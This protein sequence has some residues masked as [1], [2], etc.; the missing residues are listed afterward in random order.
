M[1]CSII[2]QQRFQHQKLYDFWSRSE[3]LWS[4]KLVNITIDLLDPH[5]LLTVTCLHQLQQPEFG[6]KLSWKRNLD[7]TSG[8]ML[9]CVDANS[10]NR[11]FTD[12]GITS[13]GQPR[14]YHY[15]F[16]GDKSLVTRD[17]KAEETNR[18]ESNYQRLRELRY[19]GKLIRRHWESKLG[20]QITRSQH[21][22]H[23]PKSEPTGNGKQHIT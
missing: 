3:G 13:D 14:V 7:G 9:W 18:F 22:H 15:D 6:V 8:Q 20:S 2:N 1:P 17:G 11:V 4:S 21:C 16:L 19:D 12:Q 5:D 10:P 23:E